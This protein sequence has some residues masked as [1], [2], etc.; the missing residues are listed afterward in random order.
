MQVSTRTE[1]PL[2]EAELEVRGGRD[3]S[4]VLANLQP[5]D[6]RG[7]KERNDPYQIQVPCEFLTQR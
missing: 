7:R 5:P 4:P 6:L 2:V 1:L 3:L